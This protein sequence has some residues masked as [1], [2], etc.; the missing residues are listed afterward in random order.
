MKKIFLASLALTAFSLAIILFQISSCKK[1]EAQTPATYSIEGL[2]IGTYTVD[3]QPGLGQQYYSFI[4]KP[5]GTII[6]DGKATNQ[7]NLAIGTWSLSG[8]N[9]S[10]SFTCVYGVPNVGVGESATAS[11][12]NTGELT[13]GIWN[14]IAPATGS[15]TFVMTRVN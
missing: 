6:A 13:S 5:D 8:N 2:W 7:Q 10:C 11:W 4:I 9:F 1:A 15:G 14:N 12:S 3:G